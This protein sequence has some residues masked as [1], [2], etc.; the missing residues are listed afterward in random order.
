MPELSWLDGYSGQSVDE[1][2]ALEG[3]YRTDSLVLAFEQ[4]IDQK[5]AREGDEKLSDEEFIILAIEAMEREVNNGGWKQFFVNAGHFGPIIVGALERIGC[6]TTASI[7]QTAV[8]IVE[9]APNTKIENGGW[10]ENAKRQDTLNECDNLYF[11]R[12]EN[13]EES[14]FTFI[15][16]NRAKIEL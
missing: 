4:A 7:A 10:E 1:L 14:L 5:A 13:I 9:K 2:I 16:V 6:P 12:P 8:K 3:K 15:K 11:Q